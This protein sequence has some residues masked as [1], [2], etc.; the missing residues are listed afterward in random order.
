MVSCTITYFWKTRCCIC[1]VHLSPALRSRWSYVNL[2]FEASDAQ[3]KHMYSD[4]P[5][6]KRQ[7]FETRYV[8]NFLFQILY[9]QT[10]I[11]K[12]REAGQA[13]FPTQHTTRHPQLPVCGGKAH[14]RNELAYIYIN[15]VGKMPNI[16]WRA[17]KQRWGTTDD[18]YSE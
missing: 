9:F 14:K 12:P 1:K 4:P 17:F 18:I 5:R 13:W 7:A 8:L 2:C 3:I 15:T 10:F 6:I 16:R 11:L